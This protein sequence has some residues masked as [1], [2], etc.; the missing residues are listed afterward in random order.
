VSDAR[1]WRVDLDGGPA[2][3]EDVLSPAERRRAAAIV[4]P[5]ARRRWAAAR[6]ALRTLLGECLDQAPESVAL[7]V[8]PGGKPRLAAAGD[9][10]FN[11]SH[12]AGAALIAV[13]PG[14]EVGVDLQRLGDRPRPFY[15]DWVRREAIAK[16]HGTGLGRP[17]PHRPVKLRALD[18]GPGWAAALA[19]G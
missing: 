11:L 7:R 19:L 18:V 15:E 2:G 5:V 4:R 13:C 12:S 1:L 8:D 17:L 6:V 9:L 16:C 10:R 14:R 3:A